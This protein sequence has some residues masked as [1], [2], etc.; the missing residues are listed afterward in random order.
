M[1]LLWPY[2]WPRG[3][4]LLQFHVLICIVCLIGGRVV[5][6]FIPVLYKNIGQYFVVS[7]F[8]L[9]HS[10]L[11]FSVNGLTNGSSWHYILTQIS[12]F[13][14][15]KFLNGGGF[16]GG[17]LNGTRAFLWI[18]VQQYTTRIVQVMATECFCHLLFMFVSFP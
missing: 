10:F 5:N 16:S 11:F 18:P 6:L 13:V 8:R 1:K 9:F 3:H 7:F 15:L 12:L 14:T 17:L 4:L 2:M